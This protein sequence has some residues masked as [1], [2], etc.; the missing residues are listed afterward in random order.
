MRIGASKS[1]LGNS[2]FAQI[3]VELRLDAVNHKSTV[4][5]I[6]SNQ[7][8]HRILDASANRAAEGLRVVEDYVRFILDDG[9]LT[10]QFK[11]LR[12]D[13]AEICAE[14]IGIDRYPA[15]DTQH[16]VGTQITTESEGERVDVWDVCAA[17]LE[18]AKQS[19]RSLEEYSKIHTPQF[20]EEFEALRYRLYT[21]EKALAITED[22]LGRLE[23]VSLCVLIDGQK[24]ADAFSTLVRQLVEA[25][26]GMI[27]LRDK[28]LSDRKLIER[29][30]TLTLLAKFS[31][32]SQPVLT[33]IND[34]VD[35]AAVTDVDGVHLGQ[36]DLSV[37]EARSIL[38]PQ[39]IVGV[40][41]HDFEQAKY[42]VL[43]GADY[44]GAGPTFPSKTKK[45]KAF[46]GLEFLR[47]LTDEITLPTFAIGGITPENLPQV[48]ET[49]IS[50]VAVSGAATAANELLELL[51]NNQQIRGK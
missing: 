36:D 41:T 22:N 4:L 15:R 24:T 21:L 17:S 8:T 51:A 3:A 5:A 9:N 25:G 47:E 18:R 6:M 37:N 7:Q 46:P 11:Q 45:F 19:L 27:Q 16:D 14:A 44:L 28:K 23:D 30:Q 29:I 39:K 40:S 43:D 10:A 1:K 26:V 20:S 33:I 49:G 38:G 32:P 34:R 50:R 48:L 31:D 35:L 2:D 12:H 13:L 42:A